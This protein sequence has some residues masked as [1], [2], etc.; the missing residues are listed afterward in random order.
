MLNHRPRL[1]TAMLYYIVLPARRRSMPSVPGVAGAGKEAVSWLT[2]WQ[3]KGFAVASV[4]TLNPH[5]SKAVV[6]VIRRGL[7][8]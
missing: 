5:Q 3:A 6:L 7:A 4:G 8:Q 2:T 1:G